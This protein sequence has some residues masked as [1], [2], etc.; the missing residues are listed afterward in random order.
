MHWTSPSTSHAVASRFSVRVDS[1]TSGAMFS[2]GTSPLALHDIVVSPTSSNWAARERIVS[3]CFRSPTSPNAGHRDVRCLIRE[4]TPLLHVSVVH[5]HGG[6][7]IVCAEFAHAIADGASCFEFLSCWAAAISNY[8]AH[9]TTCKRR[10]QDAPSWFQGPHDWIYPA[11]CNHPLRLAAPS[12]W[13]FVSSTP[14][15]YQAV[16]KG[17]RVVRSSVYRLSSTQLRHL[18]A[19]ASSAWHLHRISTNDAV[20]ALIWRITSSLSTRVNRPSHLRMLLNFR[21]VLHL[22]PH[23]TG[24]MVYSIVASD[25][26][27]APAATSSTTRLAH[28]CR[29]AVESSKFHVVADLATIYATPW[30]RIFWNEPADST[31]GVTYVTNL[32]CYNF[33]SLP[34]LPDV[35]SALA[36]LRCAVDQLESPY[37]AFP[38]LFQL[39]ADP[40]SGMRRCGSNLFLLTM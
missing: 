10:R 12:K 33:C 4:A 29:E 9:S 18:K 28:L 20:S 37:G 35:P 39:Y 8:S 5:L 14:K 6:G 38:Y 23:V 36:D 3:H 13:L 32:S 31:A 34:L 24:N 2:E 17:A 21:R 1:E 40:T 27:A 26:P 11:I 19:T 16:A 7:T 30:T 22:P 15:A 25:S